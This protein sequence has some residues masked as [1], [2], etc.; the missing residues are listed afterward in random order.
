MRS[1]FTQ[2][3]ANLRAYLRKR[4]AQIDARSKTVVVDTETLNRKELKRLQELE[5]W[6]YSV[7]GALKNPPP[8][9]A[10]AW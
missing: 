8:R 6:G 5:R 4:G 7:N 3:V 9:I 10:T 1:R 2:Q